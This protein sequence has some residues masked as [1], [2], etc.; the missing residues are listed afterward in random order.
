[1]EKD[2][3]S[4][5]PDFWPPLSVFLGPLVANI[6]FLRYVSAK[7]EH[8]VIIRFENRYGVKISQHFLHNGLYSVAFL[9]FSGRKLANYR[10]VKDPPSVVFHKYLYKVFVV[11]RILS[12]RSQ[13]T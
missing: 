4:D 6:A 11:F 1:M 9:R 10:L 5:W 7:L 8:Q 12:L 3:L 2:N 13:S